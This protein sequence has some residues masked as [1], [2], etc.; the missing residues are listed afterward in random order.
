MLRRNL[1]RHFG[2][3]NRKSTVSRHLRLEKCE[4]RTVP[5]TYMP[6]YMMHSPGPGITPQGSPTAAGSGGLLP[7]QIRGAYGFNNINFGNNAVGDGTGKT[8]AIVDAFD[9]PQFVNSSSPTFNTSDLHLFDT[10][11]G[12][13]DPPQFTK[14]NQTGGTSYPPAPSGPNFGWGGEIALDVEWAHALAP[15]AKIILVEATD[16]SNNLFTAVNYAKTVANV[17]SLSWGSNESS[18]DTSFNSTLSQSG[19]TIVAASGDNGKPGIFPAYSPNV[20]AV[21]DS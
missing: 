9:N 3:T 17:V 7:V 12:I 6:V 5:S 16:A 2:K 20:V 11:L 19:V 8:I 1:R 13:P 10:Q 4:D 15:N 18:G 21:G 14:V